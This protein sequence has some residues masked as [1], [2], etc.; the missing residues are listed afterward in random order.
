L[1]NAQ[2][3]FKSL[4]SVMLFIPF[5]SAL[6]GLLKH[7]ALLCGRSCGVIAVNQGQDCASLRACRD[8]RIDTKDRHHGTITKEF[9]VLK[10]IFVPLMLLA[11]ASHGAGLVKVYNWSDYIAPDTMTKFQAATH[12]SSTYD[13]YES[14]E[15]LNNRLL[16]KK[17]GFD[18]VMPSNHFM[19]GQIKA[20]AL[21]ALD[22]SQLPNWNNLNPV[23]LKALEGNDP[24]NRHGFPYLWGSTGIGYNLEKVRAVLGKDAPLDSWDLIF[25]PENIKKLAQ[26]GV[27]IVDNSQEML[28]VTLNYLAL[29]PHSE[30]PADYQKAKAALAA[31]RPYVSYFHTSNY[32][33]DL[34]S[35]KICVAVGF[36]GDILQAQKLARS[37]K[38]PIAIDYVV[39]REGAPLW[40]DM[41]AMPVDAPNEKAGYAFMNYLLRPEVMASISNHVRYA[42]GNEK[43]DALIDPELRTNPAVY[44]DA[45]TMERL[46]PL[47]VVAEDLE[48]LRNKLW[49]EVKSGQ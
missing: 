7:F 17:S 8:S 41:V 4:T 30:D 5:H 39:P 23:L 9:T 32:I 49:S 22:R 1:Q 48:V 38:N 20:G 42:N 45:D 44:P 26:C 31:V 47:Q 40:F 13:V 37:G 46:F 35:G 24:G 34:G 14:N 3:I 19:A 29:P 43:A 12:I 15:E 25:K 6:S 27:A 21:K 18:V 28:P 2:S 10:P 33:A 16:A 11:S 36:S